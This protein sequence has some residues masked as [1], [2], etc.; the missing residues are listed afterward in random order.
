MSYVNVPL[1]RLRKMLSEEQG[2][3]E[4]AAGPHLDDAVRKCAL[5]RAEIRAKKLARQ[6]NRMKA[7]RV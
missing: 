1:F 4:R 6:R 5:L 7:S 2:R 3:I